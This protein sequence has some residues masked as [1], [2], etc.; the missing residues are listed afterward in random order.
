MHAPDRPGQP[1]P[2]H[3]TAAVRRS[4][5]NREGDFP[6]NRHTTL[7]LALLLLGL[8]ILLAGCRGEAENGQPAVAQLPAVDVTVGKAMEKTAARQVEL[9]GSL[10]ATEQAEI[11]AK[12]S[13]SIVVLPVV[14]G[15]QVE[16][17]DLLAEINAGEINA[18]QRQAKA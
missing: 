16:K 9:M 6:M 11:A 8:P 13:G 1:A 14:L 7:S 15:S 17:G 10:Q 5:C 4:P 12:V 3:G 2:G 18:R